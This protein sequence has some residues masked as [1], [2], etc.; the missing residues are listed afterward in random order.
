MERIKSWK[1]QIESFD[2]LKIDEA[3]ELYIKAIN[4]SDEQLKKLYIDK[5]IL[6]TLY[7]IYNYIERNDLGILQGSQFDID[8]IQSAFTEIWIRKIKNGE[9]LNVD[10]YSLLF[11]PTFFNDVYKN[12]VGNEMIVNEQF[13]ITTEHIIDLFYA[14]IKLKNTGKEFNFDD[15]MNAFYQEK[16]YYWQ[17]VSYCQSDSILMIILENMYNNLNFDKIEDLEITKN[18]IGDYIRLFINNGLFENI[19]NDVVAPD[20]EDGIL[21]SVMYEN[22]IS[23][24]D[25]VIIDDRKKKVIHL[26]YGLDGDEPKNLDEIADQFNVSRERI[27]QMD[28][29]A[30]RD[31]RTSK[32]IKK[33]TKQED[34]K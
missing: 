25:D 29:K 28:A 13:G 9:L 34:K 10:R 1:E 2:K 7:V 18:K 31:L 30:L 17:R 4:S 21:D 32:K 33:Y 23:D 3:K 16:R 11:T 6:G 27:R 26:R 20:M 19:S 22:F 5:V 14:F 15:L 24:V 8:D 12:L